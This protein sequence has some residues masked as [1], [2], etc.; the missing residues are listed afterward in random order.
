LVAE[1]C[2]RESIEPGQHRRFHF[3]DQ[4]PNRF[5]AEDVEHDV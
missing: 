5:A 3:S 4:P 2:V 1:T